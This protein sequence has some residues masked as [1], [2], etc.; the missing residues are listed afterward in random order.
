MGPAPFPFLPA[1]LCQTGKKILPFFGFPL[2]KPSASEYHI[3]KNQTA[4]F[5]LY[6]PKIIFLR[7]ILCVI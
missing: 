1:L 4:C 6:L 5:M 3:I 7:R 2:D